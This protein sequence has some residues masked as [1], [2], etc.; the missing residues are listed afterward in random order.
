MIIPS[1]FLLWQLDFF[2]LDFSNAVNQQAIL[3]TAALGVLG[4]AVATVLFYSLVQR[5]GG[6]FAS[7]VTYG[8]PFVALFWGFLDHE[9]ITLLEIGCLVL[10]LAGVYLANSS[11]SRK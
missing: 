11:P 9:A 8:I 7:L 3:G 4:S 10:I 6:L 5:A 1:S 2:S